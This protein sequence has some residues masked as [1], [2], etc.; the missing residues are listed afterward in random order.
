MASTATAPA[1]NSAPIKAEILVS[2]RRA[3]GTC[4]PRAVTVALSDLCTLTIAVSAGFALW[5]VVNPRIPPLRPAMLLLPICSVAEF[6]FSG[7]YPGIGL[8]AVEHLRRTWR[9]ITL[10]YL[11]LIAAMFLTK[12]S[13][14]DSR[15]ALSIAWVLSLFIVPL[16]RWMANHLLATRSWWGAD[17]L[18]I[19]AGQA[20]RAVI[21]NIRANNILG[22]RVVACLDDDTEKKGE[23]EGVPIVGSLVDAGTVARR[24][25]TRYAIVAL[26]QMS[27]N[28]LIGHFERW[29]HIFPNIVLVPNLPGISTLWTQPRDLGGVLGLEIRHNLLN[30]WNQRL[31]RVLD[32]IGS[33]LGLVV[34]GPILATCALWIKKVSSGN[35]L[36]T[37]SREGKDGRTI[38]VF[39]IRTMHP[40]AEHMLEQHLASDSDARREWDSYCKL[41]R[42]PRILP[43]IGHLL[44][45]TS[46]DELPQLWNVLKGEMS[47]V[48]PRPFPEYHNARFDPEFRDMRTQVAPGLTGLWQVSARSDGDLEVQ[49]ALDSYYI[50]NWSLWLDLYILIRTIRVVLTQEG[51]C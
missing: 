2:E 44:R 46:L 33:I 3:Q 51:S 24:Y 14:A 25:A 4:V 9:G 39:K 7:H 18:L 13:W 26:P 10:V 38:R 43:G 16:G 6:A 35:P 47:L 28:E 19:G 11:L 5:L 27:C 22:Y 48:G 21:R 23:C 30:R 45:K 50:R 37:Q 42:D 49:Q 36:Y 41:K 1:R 34:A 15:G 29:R 31:K 32:V 20:G 17:A 40:N 12:A 8:T